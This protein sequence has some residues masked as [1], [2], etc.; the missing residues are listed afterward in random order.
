MSDALATCRATWKRLGVPAGARA[1]LESELRSHL[2]AAAEGGADATVVIG[3]DAEDFAREWAAAKGLLRQRW[4]ILGSVLAGLAA[5]V[6]WQFILELL[7]GEPLMFVDP[8]GA[9]WL[10]LPLVVF[11]TGRLTLP[12]LIGVA[13]YLGVTRDALSTRT[14]ALVL[15]SSPL[16]IL[17][18]EAATRG[19]LPHER[20]RWYTLVLALLV[21]GAR[22]AV[23]AARR[24]SDRLT[25]AAPVD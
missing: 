9:G 3:S 10:W 15:L 24:R 16:A 17:V 19:I 12:M 18:F 25:S 22:A 20:P 2:E 1:D 6:A 23:V 7:L 4:R 13:V 14:L 8:A 5:A 21:A 11:V